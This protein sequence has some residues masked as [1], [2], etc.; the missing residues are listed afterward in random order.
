MNLSQVIQQAQ[1]MAK[2]FQERGPREIRLPVFAFEDWRQVYRRPS[3]GRA[4]DEFRAY[5]K[6]TW[7]LMHYLRSQGM[8]VEPVPV[9]ADPFLDWALDNGHQ[10]QNPHELAHAVGEYANEPTSP[11][12]QCRHSQ[13]GSLGQRV[14][15]LLATIT[16]FG[17]QPQA[18]EVMSVVMH[19]PDGQV[20]DTLQILAVDCGPEQ[21]WQRAQAFLEQHAPQKVFHDPQVRRPDYCPDCNGL[22]VNLASAQDQEATETP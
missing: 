8:E 7:Y 14:P 16:V 3:D 11:V 9:L 1:A 4:L 22:L 15:D 19:R 5:Q 13:P 18:P 12:S 21:A 17:E 10:I 6:R 20:L 2:A